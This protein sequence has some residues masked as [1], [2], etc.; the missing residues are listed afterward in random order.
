[1]PAEGEQSDSPFKRLA[2]KYDVAEAQLLLRW[3][4]QNGYPVLPK[5]TNPVRTREN[6]DPFSFR[7]DD[8][9]MDYIRGLDR[10][11]GLAWGEVDPTTHD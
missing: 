7:I 11:A 6:L 9:D 8:A 4:V 5:S 10:G 2:T 3:G 1:M